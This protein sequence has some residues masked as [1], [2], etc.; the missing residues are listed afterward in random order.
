MTLVMHVILHD[1][2]IQL[3]GFSPVNTGEYLQ[4]R[5]HIIMA[6]LNYYDTWTN[7]KI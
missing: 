5:A 6:L 2:I 1:K 4:M 3:Y 7:Y